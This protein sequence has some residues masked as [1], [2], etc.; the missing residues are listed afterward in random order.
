MPCKVKD[1]EFYAESLSGGITRRVLEFEGTGKEG[2]ETHDTGRGA[3]KFSVRA[4]LAESDYL[5][6]EAIV[7]K[8]EIVPFTP[9]LFGV[10]RGR[11]KSISFSASSA[12]R[13]DVTLEVIKEGFKSASANASAQSSAS[14][15]ASAAKTKAKAVFDGID[16]WLTLPVGDSFTASVGTFNSSW[17]S[18]DGLLD[19]VLN[20]GGSLAVAVDTAS[21]EAAF[22]DLGAST[23]GLLSAMEDSFSAVTAEVSDAIAVA[24]STLTEDIYSLMSSCREVIEAQGKRFTHLWRDISTYTEVSISELVEDWLGEPSEENIEILLARNPHILSLGCITEGTSISVP[25]S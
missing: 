24:E 3:R 25:I 14:S 5:K 11:I 7:E 4:N 8:A 15:A 10:H 2:A 17:D 9:P 12:E 23:A 22:S 6:L 1:V 13:V 19:G 20:A 21:L 18:F 16:D